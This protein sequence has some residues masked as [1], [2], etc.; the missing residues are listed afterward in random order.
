MAVSRNKG[1]NIDPEILK[2]LLPGPR[3]GA[4]NFGKP[5]ATEST[6][7]AAVSQGG[8]GFGA[9]RRPRAMQIVDTMFSDYQDPP[10]T[11]N[12]GYMVPNSGYLGPNRG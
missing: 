6:G 12:W 5:R 4:P 2:S 3:S 10:C 1:P 8:Y 7:R 11:L 9:L